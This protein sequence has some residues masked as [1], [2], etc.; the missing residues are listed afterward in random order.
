MKISETI[1][2]KEF[3]RESLSAGISR[4]WR[5]SQIVLPETI[6]RA[7]I[8]LA[9]AIASAGSGGTSAKSGSDPKDQATSEGG[10]RLPQP[11][12]PELALLQ[13]SQPVHAPTIA[14]YPIPA[15]FRFCLAKGMHR[16][17]LVT[18]ASIRQRP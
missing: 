4:C 1:Q 14:A 11:Q 13:G 5:V 2:S 6:P 12:E 8:P 18:V 17:E 16:K 10:S 9:A 3:T 7:K 15:P